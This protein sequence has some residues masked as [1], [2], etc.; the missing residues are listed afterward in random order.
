MSTDPFTPRRVSTNVKFPESKRYASD[1]PW[2]TFEGSSPEEVKALI[3]ET[4]GLTG[5]ETLTLFDVVAN[6]QNIASHVGNVVQTLGATVVADENG[7][8][9]AQELAVAP[10]AEEDGNA[11]VKGLIEGATTVDELTDVWAKYR[12]QIEG[13]PLFDLMGAKHKELA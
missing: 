11:H 4:F 10:P 9:T 8:A 7:T 12:S 6:A 1:N 3:V 5:T 2:I 13:T